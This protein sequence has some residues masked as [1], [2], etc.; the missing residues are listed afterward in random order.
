MTYCLVCQTI[1][2][3]F[4]G[5][6]PTGASM[7]EKFSRSIDSVLQKSVCLGHLT[8]QKKKKKKIKNNKKENK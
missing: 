7:S 4:M 5:S 1:D 2:Q 6:I 3:D 8:E